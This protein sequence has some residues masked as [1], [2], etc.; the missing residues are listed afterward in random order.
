MR[1]PKK[2]TP[3]KAA[4][5]KRN[6]ANSTGPKSERGKFFA[7][8]NAI[9]LGIFSRD[10]LLPGESEKEFKALRRETISS[11]CPVGAGELRRVEKLVWHEWR[12]R[13]LRLAETAMVARGLADHEPASETAASTHAPKYQQAVAT[14]SKL[15]QIEEQINSEGTVS[16][17][18]QDW[19]RTL[20]YHDEVKFFLDAIKI[21]QSVDRAQGTSPNP[22]MPSAGESQQSTSTANAAPTTAGGEFTREFL[23]DNLNSVKQIFQEQQ[24][25]HGE[26]MMRRVG[27]ERNALLVP[28]EA[29]LARL[30]RY[31]DH[32]VRKSDRD[33]LALERMQRFR[34]GEEVPPPSARF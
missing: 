9:T 15:E 12:C 23:L 13:R 29:D 11:Y 20:A 17:K 4:A 8:Q 1:I 27:A 28:Q 16:E 25:R 24:L 31:E 32:I 5:N 21:V 34:R 3:A 26:H 19:L 7:S 10:M 6:A 33:E 30:I 22:A 14:L 18:N 2:V